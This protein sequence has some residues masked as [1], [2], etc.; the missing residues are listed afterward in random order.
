MRLHSPSQY[1]ITHTFHLRQA[2]LS[3]QLEQ[4]SDVLLHL[5][6]AEPL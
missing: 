2:D 5:K 1:P 3:P 4:I 6:P